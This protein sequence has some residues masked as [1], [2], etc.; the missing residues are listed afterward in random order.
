MALQR[1]A[2]ITQEAD[3]WQVPEWRRQQADLVTDLDQLCELLELDR[4]DLAAGADP[5]SD[6]PLRVPRAYLDRIEKGNPADPL[7]RQVLA[8]RDERREV[9]GYGPDPLDESAHTPVPGVLHKYHGRAL[10]VV[11]G[12]CAVHCRY[13]FRR[14]LDGAGEPTQAELE[15]AIEFANHAGVQEVILSGG[16]PLH[17]PPSKLAE[18]IDGLRPAVP[19]IRIHSRAPITFP[20]VVTDELV[21]LLSERAPLWFV[22]HANHVDELSDEVVAG[23]GRLVDAGIPVLN[24]SVLLRGVNDDVETLVRLVERLV[25]LRIRPYY[26]HHPDAVPG[27]GTFRVSIDDGLA[28]H[29]ALRLRVSGIALP[30]YVIDP[31]DGTGKVAVAEYRSR[32]VP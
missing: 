22:V 19:I 20:S 18:I 6:F 26:L 5:A 28:L 4:A 21:Q 29:D 12:A 9:P 27:G 23:L 30:Q 2:M 15:R 24:Q 25:E 10:L 31:P 17:V 13:C 16:D 8:H 14:D 11:T 1:L 3:G 7:L 32:S